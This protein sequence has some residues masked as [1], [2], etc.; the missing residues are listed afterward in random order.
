MR[1]PHDYFRIRDKHMNVGKVNL[2]YLIQV[3]LI[4][5]FHGHITYVTSSDILANLLRMVS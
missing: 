1:R 4:C 2:L 3:K 5:P